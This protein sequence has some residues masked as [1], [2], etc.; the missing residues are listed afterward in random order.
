[1]TT[2][3][4][5]VQ[6]GVREGGQFTTGPRD[7]PNVQLARTGV[8]VGDGATLDSITAQ[9]AT[10]SRWNTGDDLSDIA[11]KIALTGRPHPGDADD[12]EAQLAQWRKANPCPARSELDAADW[13]A[14]NEI[15]T[16]L[17]E[18]DSWNSG[19]LEDIADEIA[20][21]GRPHPG[22]ER[23]LREFELA[24]AQSR[25]ERGLERDLPAGTRQIA[26]EAG[27]PVVHEVLGIVHDREDVTEAQ[28][29]TVTA[30][31][32]QRWH[33][34]LIGPAADAMAEQIQSTQPPADYEYL[35]EDDEAWAHVRDCAV[36]AGLSSA[37]EVIWLR[38]ESGDLNAADLESLTP[39][40]VGDMYE[41][42]LGP[43]VDEIEAELR[44][45]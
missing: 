18:S 16:C 44:A 11:D 5:R 2:N 43:A 19:H 1:M 30:E 20:R 35:S 27:V 29:A 15:A 3:P 23:S 24:M 42:H 38:Y 9:L 14:M 32:V 33:E 22:K 26:Q 37:A 41:R 31:D 21:S 25:R 6:S 12:Y 28:F 13:H 40:L 8:V 39:E 17:G 7:E 36:L 34:Q 10:T 45:R 4:N